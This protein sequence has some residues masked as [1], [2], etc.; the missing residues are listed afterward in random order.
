M[1][2]REPLMAQ[3]AVQTA[4]SHEVRLAIL[5]S[6]AAQDAS[7]R[8]HSLELNMPLACL[9]RHLN[10]SGARSL[11][12]PKMQCLQVE[13]LSMLAALFLGFTVSARAF[14]RCARICCYDCTILFKDD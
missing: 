12:S 4:L 13:G 5:L 3:L 2:L 1:T 7:A 14:M 10:S 11:F 9:P 8:T 6:K